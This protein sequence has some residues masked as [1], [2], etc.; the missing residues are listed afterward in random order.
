M[1]TQL[2]DCPLINR[3]AVVETNAE[4]SPNN[5]W[6]VPTTKQLEKCGQQGNR[7]TVPCN[8]RTVPQLNNCRT[9]PGFAR[10]LFA[11]NAARNAAGMTWLN[12]IRR[13]ADGK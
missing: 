5:R 11:A 2:K 8:F 3:R 4:V 1:A 6:A 13:S 9:V 12:T 10:N 7:R